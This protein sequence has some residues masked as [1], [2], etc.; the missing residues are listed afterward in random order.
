MMISIRELVE[1]LMS[2]NCH[3]LLYYQLFGCLGMEYG[4]SV[5]NF[6][7]GDGNIGCIG[8]AIAPFLVFIFFA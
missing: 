6:A 3:K 8:C 1:N 4:K 5:A 2:Q 7:F